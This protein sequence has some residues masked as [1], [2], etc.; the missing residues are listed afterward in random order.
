MNKF[1]TS[2]S[3]YF[4]DLLTIKEG[5]SFVI[6]GYEYRALGDA[7]SMKANGIETVTITANRLN[8]STWI[9]ADVMD[10][11]AYTAPLEELLGDM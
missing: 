3:T 8:G 11:R 4:D 1:P 2:T 9:A 7:N 6:R 10:M 5:Q